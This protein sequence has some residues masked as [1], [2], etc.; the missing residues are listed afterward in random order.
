[1][2]TLLAY[3]L[4]KF[5][6]KLEIVVTFMAW[7]P[8]VMRMPSRCLV[9]YNA[10]LLWSSRGMSDLKKKKET[11]MMMSCLTLIGTWPWNSIPCLICKFY[12][13][14]WSYVS[15]QYF[16]LAVLLYF[17]QNVNVKPGLSFFTQCLL[18]CT[19][20]CTL[21]FT[22][23]NVKMSAQANEHRAKKLSPSFTFTFCILSK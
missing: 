20:A 8:I 15:I 19:W 22:L 21:F 12:Y 23:W 5:R 2:A 4:H 7:K 17:W 9:T 3:T 13:Q 16:V 18:A 14:D 1:M 6:H 10:R 11:L